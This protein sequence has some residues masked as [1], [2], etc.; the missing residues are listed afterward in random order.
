MSW[1]LT[2]DIDEFAAAAGDFL[3][4]RPVRHTVFLTVIDALRRRGLRAFGPSDPIFGFWRTASGTVDGAL[5][6]TPPHPMMMSVLPPEAAAAAATDVPPTPQVNLLA[7][8]EEIFAAAWRRRTGKAPSARRRTR[9]YRLEA[10]ADPS[11][12]GRARLATAG[13]RDLLVEWQKAFYAEIGEEGF[14]DIGAVM[15]DRIGYG[16]VLLWEDGDGPVSM[17][18]RSRPDSGMARVQIVYT[19]PASRGHGYAAGVTVAATR[20][21]L[22][23]DVGEVVLNTDLANPTSNRLYQRLG[24]RPVED[25]VI[26]EL[27]A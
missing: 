21:A 23:L 15:D 2:H 3:A 10:L 14:G 24:Y 5:L 1:R 6:R 11:P 25:R 26:L 4:S 27:A 18:I 17:A 19:P 22:A 9:L 12:P 7:E 13:D 16:G 20:S 8:S